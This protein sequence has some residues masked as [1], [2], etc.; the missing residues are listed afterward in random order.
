M[1][2]ALPRSQRGAA[3]FVEQ[4]SHETLFEFLA[5]RN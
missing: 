4:A 5:E 3:D 2:A 1:S